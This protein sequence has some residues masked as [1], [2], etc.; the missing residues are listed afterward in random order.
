M[1][2]NLFLF[3]A[4]TRFFWRARAAI[5]RLV[6][7]IHRILFGIRHRVQEESTKTRSL[8][9]LLRSVLGD[10]FVAILIAFGLQITNPYFVPLFT[11]MG[12][13]L[14]KES[15]YGTLLATF[16]SIGG[17]FIGFYYA[18][19]S[20]VCGAIYA[21][22]P[23][24][25]RDLL[26]QERVGNAYMRFL[27]VLTSLG[28]CLLV[29]YALGFEPIVLAMPLLLL[30]A[31]LMIIGFVR[32]GARAF[33]LFD[34]TTLSGSLF[35][36]LQ[37]CY[38]QMQ[39]GGYR[40]SDQ[41]FQ[42][43]AHRVAQTAIDTLTTVSD[44]TAKEPHLNGRPFADLCK[45][46]ILFLSHYETVKKSIP[47]DSLWYEKRYVHPAWYRT[48]DTETSIRHDTA[49]VLQPQS[50]SN[51]RWIESS[52]L[53]IVQRCLEINIQYNRHAIVYELLGHIDT[54]VKL[55]VREHQVKFAFNLMSDV[56]SW[57]EKLVITKE[58]QVVSEEPPEYMAICD[59]LAR[60]PISVLIAYTQATE[61]YGWDVIL[62]R[63][64]RIAWKSEKSIYIAGFYVHILTQLEWLRT[65]LEFEERVEG[66]V[67]SAPWYIQELI[68][69]KET[70]NFHSAMVCLYEETCKLYGDWIKTTM[71]SKHPWL[72]AVIISRESEYW[73][74]L[75]YN[76]STLNQFW[77]DLNSSRR[78]EGLPWPSLDIDELKKKKG[79]REKELLKL[80][81]CE[82][83]ILSL[84]S[85]PESYPDFAGKFLHT[86]G[87]ALFNAICEN[88]YDTV[89]TLFKYYFSGSSLQFEQL[90]PEEV[91]LDSQSETDLK[92]AVAPILD[93]MEIS[94][95]SYLLSD[96]HDTPSIKEIVVKVW[97]EYLDQNPARWI[98]FLAGA[99][100][101]TESTFEIAHRSTNRTRW[102]QIVQRLLENL[103]RREVINSRNI[104]FSEPKTVIIHKSPLVRIFAENSD[105]SLFDGIDIFIA[106]YI[107]QREDGED[108]DFGR[109]QN[110]N[111]EEAIEIENNRY[112]EPEES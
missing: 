27:A 107:R 68:A 82:N 17:I 19:I 111:L 16:T 53:P 56:F 24:N 14:P 91:E 54:Y 25:I 48:G 43:H 99:V 80:M 72:A 75:D 11:E 8:L 110:R 39:A 94:G 98:Q 7:F 38:L 63:I 9:S 22:V 37:Q 71:S 89:E 21:K 34:P 28:V 40:W 108:L 57:C 41:S 50:V 100:S 66:S 104:P 67:V 93:L 36:Q 101:L 47:T 20:A 85:R 87:E 65:R 2:S 76:M 18:A 86:I 12:F 88:D 59:L 44:I 106:K 33:H 3:F 6:F 61:S 31:G 15:Y 92:I 32:L 23:N 45:N 60:M 78:I 90:R 35:K 109:R 64:Q 81:A 29:L 105:F 95:Y 74:K 77:V 26:A 5:S 70:E 103:E 55:L 52:I 97:D 84:I 4:Q 102:G 1:R 73:S 112:M 30:S 46:L 62:Q 79:L 69:Q 10:L 42:N 58:D 83:T 49:T 13:A 51:L 96:Y